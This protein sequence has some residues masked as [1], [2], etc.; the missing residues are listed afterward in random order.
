[1]A[2]ARGWCI[3]VRR[4]GLLCPAYGGIGWAGRN[5]QRLNLSRE[6]HGSSL[7]PPG[8]ER[9]GRPCGPRHSWGIGAAPGPGRLLLANGS[10]PLQ[11]SLR[12]ADAS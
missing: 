10:V 11:L 6:L 7:L 2:E 9:G 4:I 12:P 1:L 3:V 5:S 8:P